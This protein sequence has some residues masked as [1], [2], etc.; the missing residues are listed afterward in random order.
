MW[1][2][3]KSEK[4]PT[5]IL[6]ENEKIRKLILDHPE[7]PLIFSEWDGD[8]IMAEIGEVLD[9]QQE[10][11]DEIVYTSRDDFEADILDNIEVLTGYDD[12]SDEWYEAEAERI[13][14][15]YEPYWRDCILIMIGNEE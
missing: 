12:R 3:K 10:I 11:N 6:Q 13:A 14:S 9:C 5:G 15:E 4:R 8:G 2:M 7:L 1:S